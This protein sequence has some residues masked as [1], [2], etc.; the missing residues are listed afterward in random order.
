MYISPRL[1][2]H[3]YH[4]CLPLSPW[5]CARGLQNNLIPVQ[6]FWP[7]V[8]PPQRFH[9][10]NMTRQS[11][12][13][14]VVHHLT[15]QQSLKLCLHNWSIIQT[16][17]NLHAQHAEFDDGVDSLEH[18]NPLYNLTSDHKA[19]TSSLSALMLSTTIKEYIHT[20]EWH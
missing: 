13:T 6:Q 9:S 19:S 8:E 14:H 11:L 18:P 20:S 17:Q 5:V 15:F 16:L 3:H 10:E 1:H 7:L 4:H 12:N 2:R